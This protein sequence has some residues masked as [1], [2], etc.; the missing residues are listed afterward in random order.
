MLSN[1]YNNLNSEDIGL[2]IQSRA[3]KPSSNINYEDKD[4]PGRYDGKIYIDK[5]RDDIDITVKYSFLSKS[6]DDWDFD[7]RKIKSW[8]NDRTDNKLIFSDDL[9][10]Y[11]KVKKINI[12]TPERLVKRI[13]KFEV[14]FTCSPFIYFK[15][16][17]NYQMLKESIYNNYEIAQPIYEITG[18]GN[19]TLNVNGNEISIDCTGTIIIDTTLGLCFRKADSK[20]INKTMNGFFEDLYLKKGENNFSY[21]K[22]FII[23][24]APNWRCY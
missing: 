23:K 1:V 18:E 24:I 8:L 19:L 3:I 4:V 14:V 13:G 21:T 10:M 7:F 9:E 2:F 5:G 11:Y 22:G 6:P 15:D 16:G 17:L 12:N 20:I